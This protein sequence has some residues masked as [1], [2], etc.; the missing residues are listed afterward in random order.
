MLILAKASVQEFSGLVLYLL[1]HLS[2]L[3]NFK[4][5]PQSGALFQIL[6]FE[7]GCSRFSGFLVS[8][9]IKKR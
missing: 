6:K 1:W 2:V 9:S 8:F 7:F 5:V 3:M 4:S